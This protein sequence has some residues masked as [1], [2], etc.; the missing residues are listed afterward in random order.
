MRPSAVPTPSSAHRCLRSPAPE[1][2]GEAEQPVGLAI[3]GVD[4]LSVVLGVPQVTI[5][6]LVQHTWYTTAGTFTLPNLSLG[7]GGSC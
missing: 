3:L 2:D 5:D 6:N 4:P 1:A 7:F